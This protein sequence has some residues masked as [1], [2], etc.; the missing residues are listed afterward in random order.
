MGIEQNL[1]FRKR[2]EPLCS[3]L[4]YSGHAAPPLVTRK[5]SQQVISQI[6]QGTREFDSD[7]EAEEHLRVL[8]AMETLQR[9][10]VPHIPI[11]WTDV[12]GVRE[13]LIHTFERLKEDQDPLHKVCW[14]V[15]FSLMNYLHL[16]GFRSDGTPIETI[17]P[18]T[19][20]AAFKDFDLANK[21][22][23]RLKKQ[24]IENRVERL[25]ADR[26]LSTI[27]T[28]ISQLGLTETQLPDKVAA[29]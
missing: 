14:Y 1:K 6:M 8:D 21:V 29:P 20:G 22:S 18:Y 16:Q 24:G 23:L 7:K 25:T 4:A 27:T 28:D 3:A 19:E 9:S 26:R 2:L 12:L 5:L 17:N 11:D 10:V 13:A 15:R